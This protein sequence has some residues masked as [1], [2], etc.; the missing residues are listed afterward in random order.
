M[1][2]KY[3]EIVIEDEYIIGKI[4][5]VR[6]KQV[7]LSSD[8]AELYQVETKALNQQVR[9]NISKFPARYRFQLTK[10]EFSR[11]RS[12]NVTLKRGQ[13]LKYLPYAFTEHG[14]LMLSS[15]LKS[16][17]ANRVNIFIIDTFIRLREILSI[18][19]DVLIQLEKLQTKVEDH[20]S[21]LS[22]VFEY[23]RQLEQTKQDEEGFRNRKRIGY[24][25]G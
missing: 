20:D 15:V 18:N 5:S 14:I 2:G 7:M 8:L 16:E 9:R 25:P 17:R 13:H 19:K 4:F 23:L 10:E 12:Q 24:K 22:A 1:K 6:G 11:L 21:R 3:D